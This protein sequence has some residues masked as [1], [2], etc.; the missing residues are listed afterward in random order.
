M[1]L[2]TATL[3]Y[4]LASHYSDDY[5]TWLDILVDNDYLLSLFKQISS[6]KELKKYVSAV[7]LSADNS[8]TLIKTL[9]D[10]RDHASYLVNDNEDFIA[11]HTSTYSYADAD[12]GYNTVREVTTDSYY[13]TLERISELFSEI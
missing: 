12:T 11:Y 5:L 10:L 8:D 7:S 3:Q 13:Q 2:A 4:T 6:Y 1:S 9:I